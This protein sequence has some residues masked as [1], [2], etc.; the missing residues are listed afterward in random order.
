[1]ITLS[2][3][4]VIPHYKVFIQNQIKDDAIAKY[5][6]WS[7]Y[8]LLF[9]W[10]WVGVPVI[11][12]YNAKTMEY[13][14]NKSL[15]LVYVLNIGYPVL[16]ALQVFLHKFVFSCKCLQKYIGICIRI[17]FGEDCSCTRLIFNLVAIVTFLNFLTFMLYFFLSVAVAYYAYPSRILIRLSFLQFA[18]ICLLMVVAL[19]IFV[20]HQLI[21]SLHTCLCMN[22]CQKKE[23]TGDGTSQELIDEDTSQDSPS[24]GTSQGS[25]SNGN[26]NRQNYGSINI[27]LEPAT[28]NLA[29]QDNTRE[30]AAVLQI[31]ICLGLFHAV[32]V[33]MFLAFL[34]II[35]IV[36]GGMVFE[37]TKNEVHTINDYLTILPTIA[38]NGIILLI[39]WMKRKQT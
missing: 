4:S 12:V 16:C 9:L 24:N 38:V 3:L 22:Q 32:T 25:P 27:E 2:V 17:N 6:L 35:L 23:L 37:A 14:I 30:K 10:T 36:A 29:I 11:A 20:L 7:L 18:F 8:S 33:L 26:Q 31:K 28:D 15:I 19:L 5:F 1:M 39:K 13:S 21:K 34:L